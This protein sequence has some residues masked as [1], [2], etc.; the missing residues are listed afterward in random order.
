[1]PFSIRAFEDTI[2]AKVGVKEASNHD[3]L[4]A[5]P[6]VEEKQGEI[7]AQFKSTVAI[8]PKSTVIL[9]GNMPLDERITDQ[10]LLDL[11]A[12]DLWKRQDKKAKKDEKTEESKDGK[13]ATTGG[14]TDKKE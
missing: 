5:Y 4:T 13:D 11:L 8:L 3:M 9:A 10:E 14:K 7:V 6:I 1:M 2:A 12:S